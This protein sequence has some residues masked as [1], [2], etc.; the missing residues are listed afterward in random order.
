MNESLNL[1]TKTLNNYEDII[2]EKCANVVTG[3]QVYFLD[4]YRKRKRV[5]FLFPTDIIGAGKDTATK[6]IGRKLTGR[7]V[8]IMEEAVIF[9]NI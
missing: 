6:Y 7:E 3:S 2:V 8:Q 9:T 5:G 1:I 4:N